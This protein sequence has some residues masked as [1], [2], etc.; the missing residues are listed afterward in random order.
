[1]LSGKRLTGI[2]QETW[3]DFVQQG[4]TVVDATAGNGADTVWLAKAVGP[5]GRVYTFDKQVLQAYL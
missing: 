5:Q 2:A 3:Q 1:M 4:N